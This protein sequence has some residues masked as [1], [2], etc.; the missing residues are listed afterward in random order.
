MQKGQRVHN[1]RLSKSVSL[2]GRSCINASELMRLTD[3]YANW[4]LLSNLSKSFVKA[5]DKHANINKHTGWWYLARAVD[6][7][8]LLVF[9]WPWKLNE[10]AWEIAEPFA[11]SGENGSNN[12]PK[13]SQ[14]TL[15]TVCSMLFTQDRQKIRFSPRIRHIW[16]I[17]NLYEKNVLD[18]VSYNFPWLHTY[19]S[20]PL[21][22]LIKL[23]VFLILISIHLFKFEGIL[24]FILL[25]FVDV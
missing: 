20:C 14:A 9:F 2:N 17:S 11:L 21:T 7:L 6:F 13:L 24:C 10:K 4:S 22:F 15:T 8:S 12:G 25:V 23:S 16:I 19:L 1:K 5:S 18:D 3:V